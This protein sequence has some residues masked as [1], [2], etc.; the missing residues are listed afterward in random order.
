MGMAPTGK[1]V[2]LTG[3]SA[4]ANSGGKIVSEWADY[5]ALGQWQQLGLVPPLEKAIVK[6]KPKTNMK[7]KPKAKPRA[8][9]K[10][11]PKPKARRQRR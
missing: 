3:T 10:T 6:A 7:A 8:R 5:D 1:K 9:P 11:K 2:S 4:F